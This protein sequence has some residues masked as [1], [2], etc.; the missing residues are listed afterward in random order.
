M[1]CFYVKFLSFGNSKPKKGKYLKK[2]ALTEPKAYDIL[3]YCINMDK[4]PFSGVSFHK[5][6][7]I[8]FKNS[9]KGTENTKVYPKNNLGFLPLRKRSPVKPAV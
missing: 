9:V 4:N 8:R 3:L 1:A 5:M 6:N 7:Q 2:W